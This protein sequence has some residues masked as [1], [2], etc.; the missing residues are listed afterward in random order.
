MNFYRAIDTDAI[1]EN[2]N[3][4]VVDI[5]RQ[6]TNDVADTEMS[7]DTADDHTAQPESEANFVY[8]LYLPESN[9]PID[10]IMDNLLRFVI[11][12]HLHITST[13]I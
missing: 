4:T 5:E 2:K 13:L 11:S 3:L 9:Q 1:D 7:S 10:N 12:G 8:D 6:Q